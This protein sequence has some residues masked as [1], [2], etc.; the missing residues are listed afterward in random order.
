PLIVRLTRAPYAASRVNSEEGLDVDRPDQPE[1]VAVVVIAAGFNE[2]T[3]TWSRSIAVHS[4]RDYQPAIFLLRA[5]RELGD[6][7]VTIDFYHKARYLGSAAFVTRVVE[8]TPPAVAGVTVDT[9][10]LV[11]RFL[12]TPPPPADLELRIVRGGSDNIL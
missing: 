9:V 2:G 4:G 6:K 7:R 5:G 10:G 8:Q 11:A 12:E 3:A 1:Y